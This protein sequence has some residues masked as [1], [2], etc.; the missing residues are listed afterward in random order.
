M[1]VTIE[2]AKDGR[3][4]TI[5]VVENDPTESGF[6][7]RPGVAGAK[8]EV[9]GHKGEIV[10]RAETDS[11]GVCGVP[12]PVDEDPEHIVIGIHH[13]KFN[14][15]HLRLDGTNVVEDVRKRLYG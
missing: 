9:I 8:V 10:S 7:D 4:A 6:D 12:L 15:R 3:T 5:T 11:F 14:E 1:D 13:D 2:H